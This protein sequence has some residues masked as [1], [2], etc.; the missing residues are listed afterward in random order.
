M[1]TGRTFSRWLSDVTDRVLLPLGGCLIVLAIVVFVGVACYSWFTRDRTPGL[2]YASGDEPYEWPSRWCM[3]AERC[4]GPDGFRWHLPA[5]GVLET[6]LALADVGE[7][8]Q[9]GG[10]VFLDPGY[11][12]SGWPPYRGWGCD[13]AVAE[14]SLAVGGERI[15]QGTLTVGGERP[16]MGGN[17][18]REARFI[19]VTVRR[20]DSA[21][22]DV[23]LRW[24][25]PGVTRR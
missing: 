6:R 22:C 13:E 25:R 24:D 1:P 21:T 20:T 23:V 5:S 14:W 8:R 10:E 15:A 9:V 3:D 11:R 18:P 19:R 7:R 2:S 12:P 16:W 17:V 4:G